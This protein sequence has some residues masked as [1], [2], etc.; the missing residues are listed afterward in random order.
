MQASTGMKK[1]L[2]NHLNGGEAYMAIDEMLPKI[3]F[4]DIGNRPAGLP[5]SFYELF[6]HIRFT[7]L[8]ILEYCRD[9][10]YREHTWPADYWPSE[11]TP[12]KEEAWEDLKAKYFKE[13]EQL[14]NLILSKGIDLS[15]SV[16]SNKNH[17]YFRE[18][19]LVIE[20]TS[21]HSGQLLI[22]LR[23]L[24]LYSS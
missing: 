12:D 1:Q 24:G 3:K 23:H 6:Y 13:R 7:Q 14:A 10:D 11:Q 16:P 5:Y 17:T 8:D 15:D 9:K 4:K 21:Y 22:L 20:H 19:L 18:I 2:I